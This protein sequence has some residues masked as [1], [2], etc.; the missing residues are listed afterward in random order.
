MDLDNNGHGNMIWPKN[1]GD[2]FIIHLDLYTI[3][4]KTSKQALTK[5][6]FKNALTKNMLTEV[7]LYF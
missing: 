1:M 3:Y 6:V 5:I 7:L 4:N 2:L